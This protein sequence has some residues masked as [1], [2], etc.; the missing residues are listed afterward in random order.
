M[1]LTKAKIVETIEKTTDI[2][3][4]EIRDLVKNFFNLITET[5]QQG[6]EV[7]LSGFGKFYLRDKSERPGR[8]PKTKEQFTISSRRVVK[9]RLGQKI[10]EI[11]NQ[12]IDIINNK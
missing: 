12:K 3:K 5:L 2:N 11:A 6:E 8:N 7:K 4:K 1:T 10:K 9:C